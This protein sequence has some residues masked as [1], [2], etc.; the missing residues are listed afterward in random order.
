MGNYYLFRC[1]LIASLAIAFIVTAQSD[2][3]EGI[4]GNTRRRQRSLHEQDES[5]ERILQSSSCSVCRKGSAATSRSS[6]YDTREEIFD[7]LSPSEYK[8]LVAFVTDDVKIADTTM[9][10]IENSNQALNRNYI[11]FMQLFPPPKKEAIAY[12][13]RK[14][15]TPPER[16]A[17]VTVNRGRQRPR[18]MMQY[19][20]GPLVGGSVRSQNTVVEELLENNEIP[21]SMRGNYHSITGHFDKAVHKHAYELKE[22][23]K[24]TTGGYCIGGDDCNGDDNMRFIQYANMAT[25]PTKRV[26]SVHFILRDPN[27]EFGP[28]CLLPVPISFHVIEDPDK[29]PQKWEANHYEYC[30]QGPYDSAS[31]LLDAIFAGQVKPCS[32][33]SSNFGWTSV[34]PVDPIRPDATIKEPISFHSSGKRY[35][36]DSASSDDNR[37]RSLEFESRGNEN[38]VQTN[39]NN[40]R[41]RFS[42]FVS[43]TEK[44]S[45][46]NSRNDVANRNRNLRTVRGGGGNGTGHR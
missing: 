4:R 46:F 2:G 32:V 44:P 3:D 14:T 31:D 8:S 42:D 28:S 11:V 20:I 16:Y 26:T 33:P 36:I 25:T 23:F 7:Q 39:K 1:L 35:I 13:D 37:K 29:D 45:E 6:D 27:K 5:A 10:G 9:D 15:D 34:D 22:L 19:K 43:S 38:I 21:W 40:G 12:L 30:Y 17:I 41:L 24:A 18:D